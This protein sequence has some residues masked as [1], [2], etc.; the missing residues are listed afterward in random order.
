T[1]SQ[2]DKIREELDEH[3]DKMRIEYGKK[4]KLMK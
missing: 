1:Q 2:G 4:I 3:I